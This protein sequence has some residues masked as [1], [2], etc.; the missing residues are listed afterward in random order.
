MET[1]YDGLEM[2]ERFHRAFSY[3]TPI[4]PCVPG[5]RGDSRSELR[6]AANQIHV[7]LLGLQQYLSFSEDKPMCVQRAALAIEEL[8]EWMRGMALGD[9]ENV[10]KE[11]TDRMFVLNGDILALGLAPVFPE[12]MRRLDKSN[13]SKVGP[14]GLIEKDSRGK[15]MKGPSYQPVELGDLIV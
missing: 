11:L 10:L 14:D 4:K 8:V 12:A 15:A 7:V 9:M 1:T 6:V 13:M 5:L 2:V 3:D